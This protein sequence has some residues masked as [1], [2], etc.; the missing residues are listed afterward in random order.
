MK[1]CH[2]QEEIVY[3]SDAVLVS[4]D[5][6]FVHSKCKAAYEREKAYF[7]DVIIHDDHLF[8]EWLHS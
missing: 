6:D 5:G 7:L 8:E 1:C 4:C 3:E 2:C